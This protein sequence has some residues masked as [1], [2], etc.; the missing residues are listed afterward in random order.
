MLVVVDFVCFNL[1]SNSLYQLSKFI[2]I[3]V[4]CTQFMFF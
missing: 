2:D 1:L 3:K 4:N